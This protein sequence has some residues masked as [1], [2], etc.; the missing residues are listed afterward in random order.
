VARKFAL[1]VGGL[2]L[3]LG[4]ILLGQRWSPQRSP[5]AWTAG[6]ILPNAD[7]SSAADGRTPDGWTIPGGSDVRR[8]AGSEG[9]VL[10]GAHALRIV[11]V[12]SAV[13]SPQVKAT[14]GQ[15]FR[16]GFQALVDPG[17]QTGEA[18][19]RLQVWVHWVD[20]AGDDIRIDKQ[21]PAVLGYAADGAPDW[22][23]VL[24]ET[25]PAPDNADALAISIHPLA[26]DLLFIDDLR[27]NA[28]GV[29]VAPWPAGAAA[30]V[31]FSVDWET[32][33]GGYIHSITAP[34]SAAT[35]TGLLARQGTTTLLG[36]YG[37]AGVRGTWF[38]NGYN[39]L[40]GN[41][42]GRTF[43][44]DPTFAWATAERRWR[45]DWSRRPWFGD[46]PHGTAASAPA[47]YFGDLIAP[48][49]Q[50]GQPIESHTFSHMY[51]G[52][53]RLAEWRADLDAWIELAAE[54]NVAPAAALAFP[55]GGSDGMTDGHWQ[56]LQ[57][58]GISTVTR[59]RR[60]NDLAASDKY[61][62]IDRNRYQPRLLPGRDVLAMPDFELQPKYRDDVL[63]RLRQAAAA[64]GVLDLWAHT[65]EIVSAEQVATWRGVIAA[66]AG[67]PALWVAPLPEIADYWRG[68][69][70]VRVELLGDSPLR[71]R[72]SNPGPA[73]LP[74]LTLLL[75]AAAARVESALPTTQH[76]DRLT[77]DLPAGAAEEI[78]VWLER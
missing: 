67:D 1:V 64:G 35:A 15:R 40:D 73:A 9:Y 69:R 51:V 49:V 26:D 68:V 17:R 11:G 72:V 3:G 55:Y 33:M 60:P 39:F 45:T 57:D 6:N 52:F 65:N 42:E 27:L 63:A 38:G 34:T 25:E 21:P 58:A 8:V 30:A 56:A 43:M 2:L 37:E 41:V 22:T 28:A 46:D 47:W 77:L 44:G 20:A 50:A 54:Q 12:N 4:L 10:E 13:R 16:L 59:T 29:Y 31:S 23:D 14:P 62:L 75:P 48:L 70:G 18:P 78:T 53:A 19:A 66:A 74:G 32:A 71:L 24:I 36:L 7:W 5:A 61:L 76:N